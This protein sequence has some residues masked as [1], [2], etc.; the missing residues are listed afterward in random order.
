VNE[1]VNYFSRLFAYRI[2]T[3]YKSIFPIDNPN[4]QL[5]IFGLY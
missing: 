2:L 4:M 3:P 5:F 1:F